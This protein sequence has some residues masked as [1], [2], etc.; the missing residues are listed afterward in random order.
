MVCASACELGGLTHPSLVP[1]TLLV[2]R[3]CHTD[4]LIP[5]GIFPSPY[6]CTVGHEGSGIVVSV[7]SGVKSVQKGDS[8]LLSFAHCGE[9]GYCKEGKVAACK[10]FY[11]RNFGRVRNASV[12]ARPVGKIVGE[13]TEVHG[14]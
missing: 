1:L 9:C 2:A 8:V 7:G 10:E 3:S 5:A 12:G 11:E 14:A 4:F 6:P 13:E